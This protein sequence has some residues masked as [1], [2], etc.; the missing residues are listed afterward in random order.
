MRIV[1]PSLLLLST[2]MT[3]FADTIKIVT[4]IAPVHSLVSQVAGNDAEVSLILEQGADPHH[5]SLKPSQAKSLEDAN[6]VFWIGS[7]L[8]PWLDKGIDSLA[9]NA[10]VVSLLNV[11]GTFH[12]EASEDH[13]HGHGDHDDHEEAGHDEHDHDEHAEEKHD[14]HDHDEHKEAGHD[15]HDHE[16]HDHEDHAEEKHDEHDH[17][18]H[19]HDDH[20]EEGEKMGIDAHAWLDPVNAQLWL[21]V[22]ADELSEAN[23]AGAETYQANAAA[24]S[25]KLSN[26]I[27][28]IHDGMGLPHDIPA[29]LSHDFL[30][31]FENRFDIHEIE[32]LKSHDDEALGLA[33]MTEAKEDAEEAGVNCFLYTVG[34]APESF[35]SFAEGMDLKFVE[36]DQLGANQPIGAELYGETI[37]G[38]A[39]S[40]MSCVN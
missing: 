14:E 33:S 21:K 23:P 11:E 30:A 13:D 36:I 5:Y 37:R 40:L 19:A 20:D 38:I 1:L 16:D 12:L 26:L 32:T 35:A 8:T 28:E 27:E 2:S 17:D 24:A 25:E 10:H 29:I 7:E 39:T 4:D 31:Y 34:E 9:A 22:I 15:D 6:L 18:E 3:S